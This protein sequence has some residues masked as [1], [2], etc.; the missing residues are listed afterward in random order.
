MITEKITVTAVIRKL[1]KSDRQKSVTLMASRK[2]SR[3]QVCG[4]DNKPIT[5]LVISLGCL[6]AIITVIYSGKSTVNSPSK[7]KIVTGQL[8]R[9]VAL[10]S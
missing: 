6:K 8:K 3:L 9:S 1:L 10:I 7:S 2:L 4:K 5:S